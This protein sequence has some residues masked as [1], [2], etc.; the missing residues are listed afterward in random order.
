M[1]K[2]NPHQPF[3]V[4]YYRY[5]RSARKREIEWH[6]SFLQFT[7]MAKRNCAYCNAAPRKYKSRLRRGR[8]AEIITLMN[9]IDRIDSDVGYADHNCVPCCSTCNMMKMTLT[10]IEFIKQVARIYDY[11]I[12]LNNQVDIVNE[13]RGIGQF[14]HEE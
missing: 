11:Y 9:G 2:A 14:T 6:L 7:D 12:V 8:G 1:K 13:L 10:G 4:Q 5:K 3:R